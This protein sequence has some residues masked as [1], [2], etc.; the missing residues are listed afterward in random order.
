M[1]NDMNEIYISCRDA[2]FSYDGKCAVR[3]VSFDLCRG[4]YLCILG[5][6]G[7]GK[8]TIV[9]GLLGLI[10]PDKG[11]VAY[12]GAEKSDIGY[13]PQTSSI[14]SGF[15][16]SVWETVLQGR[17]EK[18]GKR[19]FYSKEDKRIAEE[20]MKILGIEGLRN[21]SF[22]ELSG[23]QKQRVLLARALSAAEKV[24]LLDEPVS[25]LDPLVTEEMYAIIAKLNRERGLS[26]VMVSHDTK[27]AA[28][29]A[30]HILHVKNEPLFFGTSEE[31]VKTEL[32]DEFLGGCGHEHH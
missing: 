20:N 26:V 29:Y 1:A 16:A 22:G 2:E 9:K 28:K 8:S 24:L 30:T 12:T 4:E 23:G 32:Y 25:G 18:L 3:N 17:C 19:L 14:P 21:S 5:E 11:S 15:P 13:L 31:Y 7:T 10:K 27:S 6:N